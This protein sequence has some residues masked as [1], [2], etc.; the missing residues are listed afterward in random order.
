METCLNEASFVRSETMRSSLLVREIFEV[1]SGF[2]FWIEQ[3]R[4]YVTPAK[5]YISAI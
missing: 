5:F 2:M 4:P 1:N 3:R